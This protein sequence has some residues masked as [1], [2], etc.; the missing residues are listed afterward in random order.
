MDADNQK[1]FS[2]RLGGTERESKKKSQDT[3][4]DILT[5]LQNR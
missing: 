4:V 3:I 5:K 2:T 1:I